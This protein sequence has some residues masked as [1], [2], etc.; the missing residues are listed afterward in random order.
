MP[1]PDSKTM[2]EPTWRKTGT[3]NP[4]PG[5]ARL[6]ILSGDQIGRVFPISISTVIGRA[7]DVDIQLEVLEISRRHARIWFA[8][9]GDWWIDDQGSANGIWVDRVPVRG[10]AKLTFGCRIQLGGSLIMVFTHRDV[11]ED[12][13]FQM[14][15]LESLGRLAGEVAHDLRNL[16]MVYQ[17]NIGLL[18]ESFDNKELLSYGRLS[19]LDLQDI[20]GELT[21]ATDRASGLTGRLLGFARREDEELSTVNIADMLAEVEGMVRSTFPH[22]IEL[23]CRVHGGPLKIL[24][25]EGRIHQALMN[26]CINARDAMAGGGKICL[27]ARCLPAASGNLLELPLSNESD[28]V[29]VTVKD[30]GPGMDEVTLGQIFE[31][32]FTTKPKGQGTGLGLATVYS[33]VKDHGGHISV[34]SRPGRGTIFTLVFPLKKE[35]G[36]AF[37]V[38]RAAEKCV[39]FI[40][41]PRKVL[42]ISPRPVGRKRL[43]RC[44]RELALSLLWE[45]LGKEGLAVLH[46]ERE[47]IAAVVL[48]IDIHDMSIE[49][50]A[51]AI[52]RAAPNRPIIL[53]V[54][55]H[56]PDHRLTRRAESAGVH[57]V[58]LSPIS[59]ASL[60]QA[61]N[62]AI[63]SVTSI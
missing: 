43:A 49:K 28:H 16:L 19:P 40:G 47:S 14:Q 58:L 21:S 24:A 4:Q 38:I 63:E 44:F 30:N 26:L 61:I 29:M 7:E 55:D 15:K 48:D 13:I 59:T 25:S 18:Q 50:A 56:L 23:S 9:D 51:A 10:A 53:M 33:V 42:M 22:E 57:A 39:T 17:S 8:D 36:E 6:V 2:R 41:S 37:P 46:Q 52:R 27:D 20:L 3:H 60:Q 62:H 32:F 54:P 45:D 11:L 1:H 35:S 31:P 12:Q 5:R 34:K